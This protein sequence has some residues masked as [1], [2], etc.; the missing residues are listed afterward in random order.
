MPRAE[1]AALPNELLYILGEQLGIRDLNALL[2]TSR[3]MYMLFNQ[4]LYVLAIREKGNSVLF[5]ACLA[6]FPAVASRCLALGVSAE[7]ACAAQFQPQPQA[8]ASSSAALDYLL[9][10]FVARG[11]PPLF[12]AI[13]RGHLEVVRVLLDHGIDF[14]RPSRYSGLTPLEV[15]THYGEAQILRLLISRGAAINQLAPATDSPLHT[16]VRAVRGRHHLD[17]VRILLEAEADVNAINADYATPL[18]LAP[19]LEVAELL[20]VSGASVSAVDRYERTPLSIAIREKRDH[21]WVNTLLKAGAPVNAANSRGETPIFFVSTNGADNGRNQNS[22]GNVNRGDSGGS[23]SGSTAGGSG[24]GSSSLVGRNR[25]RISSDVEIAKVLIEHRANLACTDVNGSTPLHQV[26]YEGDEDTVRLF[27]A[28]GSR[29]YCRDRK[30]MTPLHIAAER[31][32][33]GMVALLLYKGAD[34]NAT[35]YYRSTPLHRMTSIPRRKLRAPGNRERFVEVLQRLLEC[36]ADPNFQDRIGQTPLMKAS[37]H[38]YWHFV[39][40]MV[41][42][43][44]VDL[45]I[46]DRRG[47][48]AAELY[49]GSVTEGLQL[50]ADTEV[51]IARKSEADIAALRSTNPKIVAKPV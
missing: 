30:G 51:A 43:G 45:T 2:S 32:H 44:T 5:W 21:V 37:Y 3:H 1:L 33:P 13:Q 7:A 10:P 50:T 40:V 14:G 16:A 47:K 42:R 12:C 49:K 35:N 41:D 23:A 26:C 24:S 9:Q 8:A 19:S 27:L 15:A 17:V 25:G 39:G 4:V 31:G 6:G 48:T 36:E 18:H 22:M 34:P 20:I 38:G 29:T 46:R 11:D 28:H